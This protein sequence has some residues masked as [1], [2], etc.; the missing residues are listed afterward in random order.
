M[1]L[2]S[3]PIFIPVKSG[4]LLV[5]TKMVD[6]RWYPGMTIGQKQLSIKSLHEAASS[7][8]GIGRILEISTKSPDPFGVELS[9]FSLSF[10][11]PESGREYFL[12]SIYQS[13]KRFEGGGP[14]ADIRSMQPID[15]K[16]DE[17]LKSSGRLLAFRSAGIE[18]GLEPKTAFY[19]WLY[20]NTI[21]SKPALS[22]R[23]VAFDA[24]T[25]IEFN[26]QKSVNCQAY[27]AALFVAL[28]YRNLVG[29]ALSSKDE[30]LAV[31]SEFEPGQTQSHS[32][33]GS[34][35]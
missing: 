2:A 3:R 18:W 5:E 20:L 26:P 30:F 31:L 23:I 29:K 14:Y 13:S 28:S 32:A 10:A 19:D 11:S 17:R 9:A 7:S 27:S 34:L 35:F 22:G 15:A 12:E 33:N 4:N 8:L 25:D 21:Y 1:N 16:R 24:F 6:F